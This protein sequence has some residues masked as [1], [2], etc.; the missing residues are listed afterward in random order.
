[1]CYDKSA[2]F[3]SLLL[4]YSSYGDQKG[5]QKL[6]QRAEEAGKYNVAFEAAYLLA[7]VDRCLDVLVKAKRMGE[8]A[9]F[10][11]AHVPSRLPEITK[12]W[13]ALLQ[14]QG[15]PF[16]PETMQVTEGEL[17]AEKQ[18]RQRYDS[19]RPAAA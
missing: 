1:M 15:L 19:E 18:L 2:D 10:A 13:A 8:A 3:N 9:F 6:A 7:D 12:Q 11:K 14:E 17:E 4:F 5:L 16:Q